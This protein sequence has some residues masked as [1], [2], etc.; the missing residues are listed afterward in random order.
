ML[1]KI[2]V[3]ILTW[4]AR[5][6]L[7]RHQPRI[8]AVTGS[9][10]KTSTKDA[11]FAALS[12][13]LH[14]RKSEKSFN[15]EIG[16]PL[17]ILGLDNAWHNPVKWLWNIIRGLLVVIRPARYPDW[18]VL[19]VGA[20][21]PG[22]IRSIASW[23]RPDIALITGIPEI[24]AHVEYFD[25]PEALLRE[26]SALIEHLKPGGTFIVNGDDPRIRDLRSKYPG[27]CVTY[28]LSP[29]N[30]YSASH[31]EI[32]YENGAPIGIRFRIEV[33]TK[34][35][36]PEVSV[37]VSLTGALGRPRV[38][39]ALAALTT[40]GA[41]GIDAVSAAGDLSYWEPSPGRLRILRGI[42]GSTII[43]DTYNSSPAAA[44]AALDTLTSI[45][46]KGRKIAIMGDMLE[47]GKYS[48]D[49]HR[50]VGVRAAACADMLL[51]VGFR[52]RAIGEA[53]LD[54]GMPDTHIREYEQNESVR[55]GKELE[56]EIQEGDIVLIKGSQG[57]RMEKTVLEIMAE[58]DRASELLVRQ[59]PEWL[60]R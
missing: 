1:K 30:E 49:A 35:P 18:L 38:Y 46:T 10:G 47:L 57:I 51:T 3:H 7:K 44:L 24:P 23:L 54:A 50:T 48:A 12:D 5:A 21:R 20:D 36:S 56:P 14:V 8:I 52:A 59:D 29:E 4:E 58:P 37:P 11:I 25:S 43:D 17:T 55:A 26:K 9:V 27:L 2:I 6:V 13:H 45:Q 16:V 33:H 31:E 22:D 34:T 15:S 28:G 42:R 60:D 32:L 53:A 41:A 40:A 39:A 19:E